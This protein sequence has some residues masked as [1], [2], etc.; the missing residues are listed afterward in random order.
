MN[1]DLN[2]QNMN[3]DG[4]IENREEKKFKYLDK[5]YAMQDNIEDVFSIFDK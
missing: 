3:E 2:P 1:D 5:D 4:E